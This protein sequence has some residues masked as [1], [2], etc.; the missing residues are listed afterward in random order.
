MALNASLPPTPRSI[1][2]TME[3]PGNMPPLPASPMDISESDGSLGIVPSQPRRTAPGPLQSNPDMTGI[4]RAPE[5]DVSNY[6]AGMLEAPLPCT[7]PSSPFASSQDLTL[8]GPAL[9]P[10][11]LEGSPLLGDSTNITVLNALPVQGIPDPTKAIPDNQLPEPLP[12]DQTGM[13]PVPATP[14]PNS[15]LKERKK[16]VQKVM[17]YGRR[18]V[19]RKKVLSMV[20]GRTLAGPTVVALKLISKGEPVEILSGAAADLPVSQLALVQAVLPV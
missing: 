19:L 18:I 10:C 8:D 13:A 15:G 2:L 16:K 5:D 17:R 20:L 14:E 6:Y 3:S 11:G 1:D 4:G 12:L 7:V 9:D